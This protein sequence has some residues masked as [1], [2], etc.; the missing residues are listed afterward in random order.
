MRRLILIWAIIA[1]FGCVADGSGG[2]QS[3]EKLTLIW[4]NSWQACA[5]SICVW[6]L[7]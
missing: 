7:K 2:N 5:R 1:V 3:S 6:P 4:L